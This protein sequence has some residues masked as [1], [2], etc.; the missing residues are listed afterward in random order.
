[1]WRSEG[2]LFLTTVGAG[3]L[4]LPASTLKAGFVPSSV[5]LVGAWLYM[6]ISGLLIAEVSL[7]VGEDHRPGK[8]SSPASLHIVGTAHR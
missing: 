4:A 2:S 1:L 6:V 3:I 7:N 5:A 8:D